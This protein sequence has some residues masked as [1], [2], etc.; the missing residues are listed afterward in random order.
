MLLALSHLPQKTDF[1]ISV[2]IPKPD[3]S[4]IGFRSQKIFLWPHNLGKGNIKNKIYYVKKSFEIPEP[5][6][7]W[8]VQSKI[9]K[10][11]SEFFDN[12]I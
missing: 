4:V 8:F 12:E 2:L 7:F 9:V 10:F 3:D 11:A 1:A 6:K 5:F